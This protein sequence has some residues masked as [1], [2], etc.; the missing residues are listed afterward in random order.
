[1]APVQLT[2]VPIGVDLSQ[3][4]NEIALLERE[5]PAAF[6]LCVL[7]CYAFSPR[8]VRLEVVECLGDAAQCAA[9]A[10]E[11]RG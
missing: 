7:L 6:F 4:T 11:H 5:L 3:N 9:V 8:I 2:L 10:G 1:M